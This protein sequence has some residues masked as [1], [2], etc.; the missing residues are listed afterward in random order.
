MDT[1][2]NKLRKLWKNRNK[3]IGTSGRKSKAKTEE[4]VVEKNRQ[5]ER[6]KYK[7]KNV[8]RVEEASLLLQK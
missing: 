5:T 2:Q 3:R 7:A 8:R 1:I 6:Q 4:K